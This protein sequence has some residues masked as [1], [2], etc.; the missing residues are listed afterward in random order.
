[1]AIGKIKLI[2]HIIIFLLMIFNIFSLVFIVYTTV[3]LK[4]I[5]YICNLILIIYY[6]SFEISE[7][8]GKIKFLKILLKTIG[9]YRRLFNILSFI[10]LMIKFFVISLNYSKYKKYW[11][12]CPFT[13]TDENYNYERR[14]ELYNIN[15]NS[16]YSY[17]YICSY[18][19]SKEFINKELVSKDA[20]KKKKKLQKEIK[21][22]YIICNPV[23][24]L[25]PNNSIID[26]F[27]KNYNK[28]KYYCS[29]TDKPKKLSLAKDKD[30]IKIKFT[31]MKLTTVFPYIQFYLILGMFYIW[32]GLHIDRSDDFFENRVNNYYSNSNRSTEVSENNDQNEF[33]NNEIGNNR[34]I[35][36][37]NKIV[38]NIQTNINSLGP[39]KKKIIKPEINIDVNNISFETNSEDKKIPE[40]NEI[41][42]KY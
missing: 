17:Q 13:I 32:P 10:A 15:N 21:P 3:A 23:I 24:K 35:I 5:I 11:L 37:E 18:D 16:R 12:N 2:L 27:N 28:N 19:S 41:N 1:M 14:C 40:Q 31:F 34:N 20:V 6:A 9:N 38:Y 7:L 30:C 36:I 8:L 26:L 42:N 29:R 39:D 33:E 22:E 4:A 25:I